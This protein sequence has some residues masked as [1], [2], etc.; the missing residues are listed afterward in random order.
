M[1]C[2]RFGDSG[3]PVVQE[4]ALTCPMA[5][6]GPAHSRHVE[7]KKGG[8]ARAPEGLSPLTRGFHCR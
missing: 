8:W 3:R 1:V 7:V 4:G 2:S 5:A 6:H